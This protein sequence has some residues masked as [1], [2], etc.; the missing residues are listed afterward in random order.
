MEGPDFLKT[1]DGRRIAYHQVNV[2]EPDARPGV[3]FFGGFK[4]DMTGAKAVFLERTCAAMGLAYLRFDYTGHGA[5]SGVFEDGCI[6]DWLRDAGDA[7]SALTTGPQIYI[8]SSMGGW[9]ALLLARD[10]PERVA[11]MI[12]IAAAPDFT[13]DSM[14]AAA[15]H[16]QRRAISEQ[17]FVTLPSEYD[18]P[19]VITKRLIANGREHL[20]LRSPLPAPFP[21]RLLHG[22]ADAD[23]PLE[24]A[25]RLHS[26]LDGPDIRLTLVQGSDHRMSGERELLLLKD[27][28][29]GLV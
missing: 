9:I 15:S 17:G 23:V 13:E 21:V 26:H 24:H 1:S 11:A 5:S 2:Q 18:A 27:T 8:G 4:S 10:Q 14:W 28:L 20:L 19:Y 6:G 3:V 12:G 7:V 22:T 16:A 25:L 29:A